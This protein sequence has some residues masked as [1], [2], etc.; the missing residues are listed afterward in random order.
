MAI[1]ISPDSDIENEVVEYEG[2]TMPLELM[3]EK[4]GGFIELIR[5]VDGRYIVFNEEGKLKG[6]PFNI[7]ATAL[8]A[9]LIQASDFIVGDVLL[10]EEDE[11]E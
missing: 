11:I 6:L 3:Q 5:L 8:V 7:I 1:L 4:V 10:L 2:K 9:E